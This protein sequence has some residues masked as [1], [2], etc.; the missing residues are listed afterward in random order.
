M[1]MNT[2]HCDNSDYESLSD[3]MGSLTVAKRTTAVPKCDTKYCAMTH[4]KCRTAQSEAS[5]LLW[6]R[7]SWV[8]ALLLSEFV[9]AALFLTLTTLH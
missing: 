9:T 3:S 8:L 1:S 5:R 7:Y 2:I 6:T 4:K